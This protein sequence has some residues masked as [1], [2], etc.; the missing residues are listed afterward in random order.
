MAKTKQEILAI[1]NKMSENTLM[2]TL[3]IVYSD[4]D[5]DKGYLAA[6]MPVN[7]KVHQPMGLLHGGASAA[8]AESLGSAASAMLVDREKF[9]VLGI[10]LSCNHLKSKRSGMVT[11]EAKII[12]QGRST[13]LW[14]IEI[15]DE[16]GKLISH[17]KLNNMIVPNR[18]QAAKD[19]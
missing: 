9:A 12:H 4:V 2:N 17:C 5:L 13:H 19:D 11:G 10:E 8:L 14:S 18:K 16:E 15:R 6:T 7:P 1:L 3:G